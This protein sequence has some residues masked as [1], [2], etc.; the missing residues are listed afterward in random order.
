MNIGNITETNGLRTPFAGPHLAIDA[1]Y[2]HD[3]EVSFT[4]IINK[5]SEVF[6]DI[7][8]NL[9]ELKKQTYTIGPFTYF[10]NR[11]LDRLIQSYSDKTNP[12]KQLY[13]Q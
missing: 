5:D 6:K 12:L 13:S 10:T 1:L 11:E 4:K 2:A 3:I 9:E 7:Q 8:E